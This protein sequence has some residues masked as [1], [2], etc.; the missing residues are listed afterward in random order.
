MVNKSKVSI[1]VDVYG[2]DEPYGKIGVKEKPRN[3]PRNDYFC[4]PL[5]KPIFDEEWLHGILQVGYRLEARRRRAVNIVLYL[6][7]YR[8][9]QKTRSETGVNFSI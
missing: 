2:C 6:S 7:S 8:I 5:Q 9:Q 3:P 4:R 1:V